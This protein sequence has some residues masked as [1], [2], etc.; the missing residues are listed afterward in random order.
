MGVDSEWVELRRQAFGIENKDGLA[1]TL[2]Q[3][4]TAGLRLYVITAKLI[5]EVLTPKDLALVEQT[6]DL[7]ERELA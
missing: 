6:V 4:T 2:R 5:K 1:P 7:I 3:Q